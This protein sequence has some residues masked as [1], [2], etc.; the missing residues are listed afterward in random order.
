MLL[1]KPL[2][3]YTA[4]LGDTFS[5]YKVSVRACSACHLRREGIE[6]RRRHVSSHI[7]VGEQL[8]SDRHRIANMVTRSRLSFAA[9]ALGWLPSNGLLWGSLLGDGL[10]W[11]GGRDAVR[12]AHLD[13]GEGMPE[14]RA[15]EVDAKPIVH[16][17]ERTVGASVDG[18]REV[19][20]GADARWH[21]FVW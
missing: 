4:T 8:V 5:P 19:E 3:V 9:G 17:E 12:T 18:K 10:L 7:I 6:R 21:I 14:H 1:S 20:E 16:P 15:V 2:T 11:S 13:V